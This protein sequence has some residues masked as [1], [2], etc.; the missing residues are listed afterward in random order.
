MHKILFWNSRGAGSEKFRSDI[1]DLVKLHSIDILALCEPRVQF[2]K[3]KDTLLSL[4]FTDYKIVEA[5][6]FSG[7]I[8]LFWSSNQVKLDI[9]DMNCQSITA[10][11]S[12]PNGTAWML[13]ALYASPTNSVRSNL[14]KYLERLAFTHHLPWIFMGDFNELYSC[15]DKNFGTISG[16]IGGLKHWVDS[17]FLIDMGFLGS[18]DTWS[19]NRIKERL[20][21]AFCT[22][23]WRTHFPE[24]FIRHLPKMKSDHCPILLQLHSNNYVNRRVTPFRFQAMWLTHCDFSTFVADSWKSYSGDFVKKTTDL[25][26]DLQQWNINIFGNIFKRK[27][28]LLARIGGIQKAT[29][30]YSNPFLINLESELIREYETLR[31]QENLFWKQKSR[32]KWL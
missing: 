14:W 7:G 20:D 28:H 26:H 21:R 9:I 15:V 29:D 31:D 5:N 18:C 1:I 32:D 25:S 30:R 19:N 23:D 4:G 22:C 16:R 3:A 17:N 11:I 8:W 12:Q 24:A 6:G 10:K 13:T 2:S 27:K